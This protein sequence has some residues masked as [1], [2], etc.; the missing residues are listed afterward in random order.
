MHVPQRPVEA[1][2]ALSIVFVASELVHGW[3]GRE[4]ITARAPWMV[5][6]TFGLLHGLGFAGALSEVGLPQGHIPLALL[7]FSVG[8]EAG[9]FLCIRVVLALIALVRRV[10]LPAPQWAPLVLP[11]AIGSVAAFWLIQRVAGF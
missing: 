8:V 5:A 4:G 1:V 2:T 3:Q 9:H 11:C 7:F 10:K 6:L